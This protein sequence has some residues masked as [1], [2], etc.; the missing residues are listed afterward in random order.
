LALGPLNLREFFLTRAGVK[1]DQ[2]LFVVRPDA[3]QCECIAGRQT[4]L[5][6]LKLL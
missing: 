6:F 2:K 4:G 5:N 3:T 1:R